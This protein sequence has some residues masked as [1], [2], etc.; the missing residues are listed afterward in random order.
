MGLTSIS[1]E[2]IWAVASKHNVKTPETSSPLIHQSINDLKLVLIKSIT[3][4]YSKPCKPLDRVSTI[5]IRR[6]QSF[7]FNVISP[8]RFRAPKSKLNWSDH[9]R[10]GR[11]LFLL[12]W[13]DMHSTLRT[14]T[15]LNLRRT[16]S[17]QRKRPSLIFLEI[18]S[19]SK[20]R[21]KI[22]SVYVCCE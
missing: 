11:P 18:D 22:T 12:P 15:E 17:Y 9:V 19:T 2:M 5:L 20:K 1:H 10:R 16:C 6:R 3:S 21:Q 4:E 13:T 8:V 14:G 7:L